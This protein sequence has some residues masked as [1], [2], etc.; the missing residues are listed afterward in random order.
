MGFRL[1]PPALDS[2]D[3]RIAALRPGRRTFSCQAR[4]VSTTPSPDPK[5]SGRILPAGSFHIPKVTPE[6][7][8]RILT[9]LHVLPEQ[10]W[11]QQFAV[12]ITLS[13]L[14]A[15]MGL[16]ADSPALV[17]GAMLI[18]PLMAPVLGVAASASMAL[19]KQAARTALTVIL[20]TAGVILLS[21]LVAKL[22]PG[23]DSLPNEVLARTRP[24]V[25]DLVVGLA[26][27]AAGAYATVRSDMSSSLPGVAVAVALVPP[28][29]AVGYLLESGDYLLARGAF[30]L[31]FANLCAIVF[32]GT[33][34]F[35]ITGLVP[36]RRLATMS[37][38]VIAGLVA[39]AVATVLIAIPLGRTTLAAV[40]TARE[41]T[42]VREEVQAWIG[43][44]N[45]EIDRIDRDDRTI[46]IFLEGTDQADFTE[47]L[48]PRLIPI[49]G[50]GVIVNVRSTQ[51]VEAAE[52]AP[53]PSIPSDAE[54][55]AQELESFQGEVETVIDQWLQ[56][57]G[58]ASSFSLDNLDITYENVTGVVAGP[59]QP[60]SNI[61]LRDQIVAATGI[62]PAVNLQWART[63]LLVVQEEP[64][65]TTEQLLTD[66]LRQRANAWAATTTSTNNPI[67]VVALSLVDNGVTV[68]L[69]GDRP[70]DID[71]L[72]ADL[73]SEL[74]LDNP[75]IN[76]LYVPRRVLDTTPPTTLPPA[77]TIPE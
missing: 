63:E 54:L 23:N 75:E 56:T 45:L 30:T 59:I 58:E 77:T 10:G 35:V 65:P 1:P 32:A 22:L 70:P 17:I 26:A 20:A 44:R 16:D 38:W 12:M 15:I 18:A 41:N 46:D 67:T 47:N 60:P 28:L 11:I 40:E 55:A 36:Q 76:I 66:R 25:R 14:V 6:D 7:R 27:G 51:T 68:E 2:A 73:E 50:E 43:E 42:D 64:E 49:L 19:G 53:P 74:G 31:Y 48:R 13:A 72:F 34:V 3:A 21:Y 24:D 8:R 33:I 37:P 9:S 5:A 52:N 39:A 57:T 4:P 69:T 61:A 29:C 62:G 71:Q